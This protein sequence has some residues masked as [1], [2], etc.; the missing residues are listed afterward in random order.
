MIMIYLLP[1]DYYV[2]PEEGVLYSQGPNCCATYGFALTPAILVTVRLI[3][4][5]AKISK[6]RRIAVMIRLGVWTLAAL[7]QFLFPKLPLVGFASAIGMPV[8]YLM[9]ENPGYNIDRRGCS[10]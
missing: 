10:I 5:R 3:K 8:L 4:D 2:N 6:S 9:P 1:I 7:T